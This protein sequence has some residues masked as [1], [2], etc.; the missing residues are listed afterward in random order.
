M[1]TSLQRNKDDL[2]ND[3]KI[4]DRLI[5]ELTAKIGTLMSALEGSEIA[6]KS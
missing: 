6:N 5:D 2:L 1:T 3:I 4:K